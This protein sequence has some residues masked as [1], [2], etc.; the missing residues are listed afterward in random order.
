[1]LPGPS[2]H[3]DRNSEGH[4]TRWLLADPHLPEETESES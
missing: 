3:R 2:D 1:M 4:L